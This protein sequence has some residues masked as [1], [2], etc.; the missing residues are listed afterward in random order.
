MTLGRWIGLGLLWVSALSLA[1]TRVEEPQCDLH[2]EQSLTVDKSVLEVADLRFSTDGSV[3]RAGK[4]VKLNRDQQAL[5]AE[6]VGEVQALVPELLALVRDAM[7]LVARALGETFSELFGHDSDVAVK[8]EYALNVAS[9]K[10]DERIQQKDGRYHLS[11]GEEDLFSEAFGEEFDQAVEEAAS[12]SV[13]TGMSL[14]WRALFEPGFADRMEKFGERME[15]EMKEAAENVE[16]RGDIMCERARR[17][18]ALETRMRETIPELAH[19]RLVRY[20]EEKAEKV[21]AR[22]SAN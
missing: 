14:V 10:L 13:G 17:T 4:P 16:A 18:A 3:T 8:T 9:Q 7:K 6:Y 22:I 21:S 20:Q 1:D 19:Y 12:E 2:F 15:V 11:H 5:S